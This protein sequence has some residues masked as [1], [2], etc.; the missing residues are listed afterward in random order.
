MLPPPKA[1]QMLLQ[2]PR[3]KVALT[4]N[5]PV[6]ASIFHKAKRFF[7][8]VCGNKDF[9]ENADQYEFSRTLAKTLR[10]WENRLHVCR[11]TA[12]RSQFPGLNETDACLDMI[13]R[14]SVR[15]DSFSLINAFANQ[16]GRIRKLVHEVTKLSD[17]YTRDRYFWETLVAAMEEFQKNESE[18]KQNPGIDSGLKRL[19]QIF[20]SSSPYDSV[21]EARQLFKK[22]STVN[23]IIVE[24]KT[25]QLRVEALAEIGSLLE[26]MKRLL[27]NSMA[28]GDFRN[29]SLYDLR[30]IHRR[31]ER[32]ETI[33]AINQL[34]IEAEERFEIFQDEIDLNQG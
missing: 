13:G 25:R 11:S 22:I 33:N 30:E 24:K 23:D 16:T 32:A 12:Q 29:R 9:E 4:A 3:Q 2:S 31:T 26:K 19:K 1:K 14:L 8:E 27:E 28:G 20:L 15:L 21:E 6:E 5:R 34:L 10:D 17:F 7:Q 18:L